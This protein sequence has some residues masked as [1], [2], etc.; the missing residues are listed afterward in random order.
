MLDLVAWAG[1]EAG[2][3]DEERVVPLVGSPSCPLLARLRSGAVGG[4]PVPRG[5]VPPPRAPS[6]CSRVLEL[7]RLCSCLKEALKRPGEGVGGG[8]GSA[9]GEV[10]VLLGGREVSE[11]VPNWDGSNALVARGGRKPQPL[12]AAEQS[13]PEIR[14]F[15]VQRLE[16][17]KKKGKTK[18]TR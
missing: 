13:S 5:S 3:E 16:R 4:R 8:G 14:G 15:K 11:D 10:L 18:A 9:C 1:G 6:P 2:A 12:S 17:T 7:P